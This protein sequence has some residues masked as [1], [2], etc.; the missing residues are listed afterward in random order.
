[1]SLHDARL[2][3]RILALKLRTQILKGTPIITIY[4]H[5]YSSNEKSVTTQCLLHV[6]KLSTK[7]NFQNNLHR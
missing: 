7:M 4:R 5:L 1:M 6:V 3:L 2:I